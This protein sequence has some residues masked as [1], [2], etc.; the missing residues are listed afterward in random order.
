[1]VYTGNTQSKMDDLGVPVFQETSIYIYIIYLY[2]RKC[3][4]VHEPIPFP[5]KYPSPIES[6]IQSLEEVVVEI[7]M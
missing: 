3:A 1:M 6:W 7:Q 2:V 4:H 5:M